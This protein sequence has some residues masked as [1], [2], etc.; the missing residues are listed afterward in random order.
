MRYSPGL[1]SQMGIDGGIFPSKRRSRRLEGTESM[2]PMGRRF[3][4][5]GWVL[6]AVSVAVIGAGVV[7]TQTAI[8]QWGFILFCG[9]LSVA[10]LLIVARILKFLWDHFHSVPPQHEKVDSFDRVFMGRDNSGTMVMGD[11]HVHAPPPPPSWGKTEKK[12]AE[13]LAEATRIDSLRRLLEEKHRYGGSDKEPNVAREYIPLREAASQA[14]EAVEDKPFGSYLLAMND[15][16]E[17][18][19]F[20]ITA[21]TLYGP[22]YGRVLLGRKI[23]LLDAERLKHLYWREGTD[24]LQDLITKKDVYQYVCLKPDDLEKHFELMAGWTDADL[25]SGKV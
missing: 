21:F 2:A 3:E 8:H 11:V 6:L 5:G 18:Y 19:K 7:M 22:L 4:V 24:S 13:A 15:E 20:I 1:P 16:T 17:I 14:F 12:T 25:R 9:G 23:R 10:V